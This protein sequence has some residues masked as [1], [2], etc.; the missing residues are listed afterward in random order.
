MT[1]TLWSEFGLRG[2]ERD[3]AK[4]WFFSLFGVVVPEA[5]DDLASE[6]F[7][8]WRRQFDRIR[9]ESMTEEERSN[10]AEVRE[11]VATAIDRFLERNRHVHAEAETA[12]A[13]L[14]DF[15][16]GWDE[17]CRRLEQI[18][19]DQVL[20]SRREHEEEMAALDRWLCRWNLQ[21]DWCRELVRVVL[22]TWGES[23]A[24]AERRE[25]PDEL[26]TIG[27]AFPNLFLREPY[28]APAPAL[29]WNPLEDPW[30]PETE[31][32]SV[33]RARL[34]ALAT[35]SVDEY[36]DRVEGIAEARGF[37]ERQQFILHL[38]VFAHYQVAKKSVHEVA[39]VDNLPR[40][41]V[42]AILKSVSD[43]IELPLREPSKPGRPRGRSLQQKRANRL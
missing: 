20:R 4:G 43:F 16:A 8:L 3:C 24:A 18:L 30:H 6:P 37:Q 17:A 35:R 14:E 12:T 11:Q 19:P 2:V 5:L 25:M 31:L 32:R 33:A 34:L 21:A 39:R 42:Q 15:Q 29:K 27:K 1:V 36:L 26:M 40:S 10:V 13:A 38:L 7:R 28:Q 9:P 22:D 23:P 41:T